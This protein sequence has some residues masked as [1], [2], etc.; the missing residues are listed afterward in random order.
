MKSIQRIIL[1]TGYLA[2]G[3]IASP[4]PL[5]AQTDYTG[6]DLTI[7]ANA[8]V[9]GNVT[10]ITRIDG[11]LNID[12]TITTFPN[13]AALEVVEGW[14]SIAIIHSALTDLNNIFPALDTIQ[15]GLTII[16][17]DFV[18]TITGFA[19]LDSVGGNLWIGS[20]SYGNATLTSIPTFS[21]LTSVGR[22]FIIERNAALTTFSGFDALKTIIGGLI[23]RDNPLLA[24]L[25]S[26][27]ALTNIGGDFTVSRNARLSSCCGLRRFVDGRN[28]PEGDTD[29]SN[30][31]TGCNSEAE[32]IAANC[33]VPAV[34][35]DMRFLPQP[36]FPNPL[37]RRNN[38]RNR[39]FHPH[40]CWKDLTAYLF[41]TKSSGRYRF[42]ASR[43]LSFDPSKRPRAKPRTKNRASCDR[44]VENILSL[45]KNRL[46]ISTFS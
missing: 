29:I 41:A 32:I 36:R 18:E 44:I 1:W 24:T 8:D 22:N 28:P 27:A 20:L 33:A 46:S 12:G 34:A 16:G 38:A 19:E 17:N 39:P 2:L 14:L 13:F 37:Y 15:G 23:I 4:V 6:G 7:R 31:T 11:F 10:R 43:G 35:K 21:S 3:L 25:P 40:T 5:H 30:N 42:L 9:P 26:F 45:R